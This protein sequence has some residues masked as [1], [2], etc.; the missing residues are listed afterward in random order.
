ME[1]G[2]FDAETKK[3][4]PT[5]IKVFHLLFKDDDDEEADLDMEDRRRRSQKIPTVALTG[6][7]PSRPCTIV[8]MTKP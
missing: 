5:K 8:G 6:S 3:F 1:F 7:Q 4:Q 2:I